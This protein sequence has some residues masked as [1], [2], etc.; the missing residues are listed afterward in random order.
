MQI[1][2]TVLTAGHPVAAFPVPS[3]GRGASIP[4]D[5]E[6]NVS[7]LGVGVILGVD[8]LA[9]LTNADQRRGDICRDVH[10]CLERRHMFAH[11]F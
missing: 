8:F 11:R 7:M 6:D 4:G 5:V 10:L 3:Q 1:P 2:V 9:P